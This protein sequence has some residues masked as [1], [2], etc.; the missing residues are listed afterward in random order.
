MTTR[1][2]PTAVSIAAALCLPAA[3]AFPAALG[4][5]VALSAIG[6]PFRAEI[7]LASGQIADAARC[8]RVV[9]PAGASQELPWISGARVEATGSGATARIVVSSARAVHDPALKLA[10]ENTCEARLRRE[11]TVLLPYPVATPA[12][13]RAIAAPAPAPVAATTPVT[14]GRVAA[15]AP[16]ANGRTW[17]TAPGESLDT[18]ARSLYPDDAAARR[19]F[20]RA[21]AAA[22]PALFADAST[23]ARPLPPGTAILV[24]DLRRLASAPSP[25]AAPPRATVSKAPAATA[26]ARARDIAASAQSSARDR[27]VIAA[28]PP[29][30]TARRFSPDA[31]WPARERELAAAIDRSIIAEMELLARIKELEEMQARL[32]AGIRALPAMQ[33][34]RTERDAQAVTPPLVMAPVSP[35]PAVPAL[36][37][38]PVGAPTAAEP[39]H[40]D[41]YMIGGLALAALVLA[42]LLS[43]RRQTAGRHPTTTAA[44]RTPAAPMPTLAPTPTL[45]PVPTLT[46]PP[47]TAPIPVR[48]PTEAATP[49][50]AL[51][52][53]E[54]PDPTHP[55]ASGAG[56]ELLEEHKSAVEL[57]D[58]MMSFGR[59]HGAAET[60]AEFIRGNPDQAVTP[61]LKLLE[62]YRA[63]GLRLEF[64]AVAREL[65]RTFNVNT[66]NWNNYDAL[67]ATSQSIEQLP[68]IVEI[69]QRTWRTPECQDYLQHLLRD[70]RN[71]TRNGFAF[72][73][74]DEILLL[75]AILEEELG[76]PTMHKAPPP[77]RAGK[78]FA[79]AT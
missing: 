72:T 11:Y 23:H 66:V 15:K 20:I 40:Q 9:V 65:N 55:P 8:L 49:G 39:T 1:R 50:D 17:T 29:P 58:I 54:W 33:A 18:L 42:T 6:E 43:R 64:D 21:T 53:F 67:R 31:D 4:E 34:A 73:V 32:E 51:G 5:I 60:L 48:A 14:A 44:T 27:L 24:P 25:E 30:A 19:R 76:P 10:V 41:R 7:R 35:A 47:R 62:V 56:D 75:S 26:A 77:A 68:H 79:P 69:L 36:A 38:P 28:E 12:T 59:L 78:P 74:I 13:A 61:W 71:G 63:A 45:A 46:P 57:A 2:I 3:P 70:N 52:H 16:A 22:N 37:P